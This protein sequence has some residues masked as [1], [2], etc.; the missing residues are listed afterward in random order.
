MLFRL[1]I[2]LLGLIITS[3]AAQVTQHPLTDPLPPPPSVTAQSI[4][5]IDALSADGNYTRLLRLLQRTRLV[6]TLNR[7]NH[8]TIFAP[9]NDAIEK[10]TLWSTASHEI[11]PQQLADNIQE[12][13]RQQLLY[14]LLN[15]SIEELP[16][17][18][19]PVVYKTLHFPRVALDPPTRAPPPNPPWLPVPGGTLGGEPQRLRGASRQD[20][21]WLGTDYAGNGGV[22]IVRPMVDG[23]NG[24]LVGIGGILEPPGNL[25]H[26]LLQHASLSYFQR[27]LSDSVK[28]ELANT[29]ALTLFL[30][31]DSA[32][33][34]LH[35]VEKLYLESDFAEDDVRKIV[36]MHS[37]LKHRVQYLD[38]FKN[39][40][41]LKTANGNE[42]TLY[43]SE[44]GTN[45]SSAAIIQPD[46][47]ASN[48]VLHVVSSLLIPP[49]E[50]QL[51]PEK[52]LLALNCTSFVSLLRSVSL[53]SMVNTTNAAYT[54]LA[55]R[56]DVI[57]LSKPP[58]EGPDLA[59]FLKY[60]FLPGRW[61]PE[62]FSDGMLVETALEEAGLSGGRQVLDISVTEK[63]DGRQLTFGGAGVIGGEPLEIKNT[64]IYLITKPLVPPEDALQTALPSLEFSTFLA[65]VLS[66]S[67][68][69]L[70]RTAP[71]V[72]L[73]IPQNS[74][75]EQVGLVTKHLLSP[76]S[77]PDLEKMIKHHAITEVAYLTAIAN[78]TRK[79]YPTLEGSDVHIGWA[80]NG[81]VYIS[82]SGGWDGLRGKLGAG[83]IL[84]RTGVIHG[85]SGILLP[86]SLE[87]SIQ[88]L[89]YAAE[90]TTMVNLA[91]KAGMG[92]VLNGT[93]PP[94]GSEW[95]KA[96]AAGWTLLCPTDASFKG[97]NMTLLW[98]DIPGMRRLVSQHLVPASSSTP[99]AD[100]SRPLVFED[101]ITYSTLLSQS[102]FYGDI[103]FRAADT[104]TGYT[105]RVKDARGTDGE[106]DWANVLAWGRSTQGK[107]G[108]VVQI[109]RLL[110]P[111][112]PGW[113]AE[114]GQPLA[115]G[116]VG[117][118]LMGGFFWA[119][120]WLWGQESGEATYEPVGGFDRED[121]D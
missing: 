69:N 86:R 116:V 96:K 76:S 112:E 51:T 113:L 117:V 73:F 46:I 24:V 50:L 70:I 103:I 11:Y 115:V 37:V 107:A 17:S 57:A 81:S 104:G 14:H 58:T 110:V 26:I 20:T 32:W 66:S 42:L 108:G 93:A 25:S 44:S 21:S 27:I 98:D 85:I 1:P 80:D 102:S 120:A 74:A 119:V 9:T 62:N 15:Y 71:S 4:T 6:P 28:H 23:G 83:N 18:H 78:G 31:Q 43:V 12:E 7:L 33:D 19:Q 22:E 84:T 63:K 92:W 101:K 54:I 52:Y 100:V 68:A 89:A 36:K 75:F 16:R 34:G 121:D 79:T 111:Y 95:A 109:D 35:E 91:T 64:I 97:V 56:D 67:I 2:A 8:S 30:P 40:E 88:K 65:A 72:T 29:S 61:T 94:E 59:R 114:Y 48:G 53:S 82:P 77:K 10:H 60:H 99:G 87:I 41:K 118:V 106:A 45:I 90:A 39:A 47:Y 49:G 13:L 3:N 105:V 5:L 38:T 55:P